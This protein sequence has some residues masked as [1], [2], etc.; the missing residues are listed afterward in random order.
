MYNY[1]HTLRRSALILISTSA[2]L[3]TGCGKSA[4]SMTFQEGYTSLTKNI[5]AIDITAPVANAITHELTTIDMQ[6]ASA[7]GFAASGTITSSGVYASGNALIHLGINATAFEPSFNASVIASG[8]F[9]LA[10][11][12]TTTYG[13][14]DTVTLK[15]ISG[16][17][18]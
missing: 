15:P 3:L 6:A 7:Q 5:A 9:R 2:L 14:I 10:Q 17:A 13:Y 8:A 16:S 4:T 11:L 12:G 18:D 1:T